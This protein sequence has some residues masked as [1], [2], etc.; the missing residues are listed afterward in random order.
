MDLLSAYLAY[1]EPFKGSRRYHVWSILSVISALLERRAWLSLGGLGRIYPNQYVVLCGGPGTGKTKSAEIAVDLLKAYNKSLGPDNGGIKL[2]PD[3]FTPAALFKKFA[4]ATKTMNLPT[5]KFEQSSIFLFST[6]FSTMI[7]DIGGGAISDDLL[8]LYDCSDSFE[9]ELVGGG[10]I[11]IA[12]PCLNLLACTTPSFLSSFM[13]REQSGTGLSAR[14]IFATELD[15]V[16]KEPRIPDGN[17]DLRKLILAHMG[18]IHKLSG[19]VRMDLGAEGFYSDWFYS[20]EEKLYE[21]SGYGFMSHFYSRK[22]DHLRKIA[23]VISAGDDSARIIRKEHLE[24]ALGIIEEAE[25]FMDKSFGVKD[26]LKIDNAAQVVAD[27]IP[28]HPARIAKWELI[29]SLFYGS[30]TSGNIIALDGILKTLDEAKMVKRI[31][32]GTEIFFTRIG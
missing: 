14:I 9:K 19:E 28:R 2:G 15:K 7:K 8:K 18:R 10:T 21:L 12:K 5:G 30:G 1:V 3:K 17:A 32:E 24:R 23:M 20:N 6:E 4:S 11:R 31:T 29:Q 26:F 22:P 16:P 25:P 13:P 27:A